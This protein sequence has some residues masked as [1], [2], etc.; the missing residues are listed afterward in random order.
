MLNRINDLRRWCIFLN[1]S[2]VFYVITIV[3]EGKCRWLDNSKGTTAKKSIIF[4]LSFA[5]FK[6]F[7]MH[8]LFYYCWGASIYLTHLTEYRHIPCNLRLLLLL[9]VPWL[10][11]ARKVFKGISDN[12]LESSPPQGDWQSTKLKCWLILIHNL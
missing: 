7:L 6:P 2:R 9:S 10:I 3:Q 12:P 11:S 5:Y 1:S 4:L 8:F